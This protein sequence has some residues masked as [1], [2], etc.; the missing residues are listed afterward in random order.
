MHTVF[1]WHTHPGA[2]NRHS[3]HKHSRVQLDTQ[4][5]VLLDGGLRDAALEV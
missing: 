4:V 5:S 1:S 2:F 3:T